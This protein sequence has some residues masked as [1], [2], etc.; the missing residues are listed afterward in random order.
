MNDASTLAADAEKV[1]SE[2][3]LQLINQVILLFLKEEK[4]QT[5]KMKIVGKVVKIPPVGEA[6]IVGDIH[7]D[8]HSLLHIL[9]TSSFL[10]KAR[11]D[12]DVLIIFLG[13]YG[14]RGPRSPE[15]YFVILSLKMMFPDRVI[16]LRG[17]HEGPRDLLASPH[18]LPV[19]LER[20]FGAEA[21]LIYERLTS[22]FNHLYLMVLVGN[23]YVMLHGG[24]PSKAKSI[25]DVAYACDKHPSESHLEEIL[26]SDPMENI[27]GTYP[28]P[29]GAG[30]LFGKD[31]TERFLKMLN[32]RIIIRG[33]EPADDGHKINHDGKIL[34]I[35]SRIGAP[36]YNRKG[37]YLQLNLS[38]E[39]EDAL[40]IRRYLKE[41]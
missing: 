15:V 11:R 10:E 5:E 9:N 13:D 26:W 16:L 20:K 34:T 38:K 32:A 3:F 33:H 6:I 1:G 4:I 31:V 8:L 19:Q 35:F 7:G 30:R 14:D 39:V 22:L 18:D 36:Y 40:H 23:K 25:M 27:V 24:V 28:S 2:E 17:N 41:I 12:E 37:T 21:Q 29:R